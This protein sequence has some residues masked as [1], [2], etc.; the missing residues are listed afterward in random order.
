MPQARLAF[1][2]VEVGMPIP[3]HL[4]D[5]SGNVL[6]KAGYVIPNEDQLQRLIERGTFYEAFESEDVGTGKAER[7]SVFR[8]VIELA[9]KYQALLD[10]PF[11]APQFQRLSQIAEE[12]EKVFIL[13]AD[14]ALAFNLLCKENRYSI[15]HGFATAI[16]TGVLLRELQESPEVIHRAVLGALSMNLCMIEL[17]DELY[18]QDVPLTLEQKQAIVLHP[19]RAAKRLVDCGCQDSALL[20]I[21]QDHH[22]MINGSGY[23]RRKKAP[24]ISLSSQVVSLADRYCAVVSERAYRAATPPNIA[25]RELLSKQ[26]ETID[27]ILTAHFVK[28][29]GIYPPGAVVKLASGEIA[30]VVRRTL[31]PLRPVVRSLRT[32][33]GVVIPNPPK[34][35]TSKEAFAIT[36]PANPEYLKGVNLPDLWPPV[37]DADAAEDVLDPLI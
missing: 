14:A 10:E 9:A 22:E 13:D 24:D 32:R 35:L 15:R 26:A 30:V 8:L 36:E 29:I 12:I 4:M 6:L 23:A 19:Q 21:V 34:R 16:L 28:V 31:H 37:E 17:Q 25:V 18:R 7:V 1:G 3:F 33:H 11:G 2:D 5:I 20:E 27:P